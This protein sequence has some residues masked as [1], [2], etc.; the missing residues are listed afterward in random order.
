MRRTANTVTL[1]H[2]AA[3]DEMINY[4]KHILSAIFLFVSDAYSQDSKWVY[5]GT[6]D[7]ANYYYDS[8]TIARKGNTGEILIKFV[9]INPDEWVYCLAKYKVFFD[10]KKLQAESSFYYDKNGKVTEISSI[11]MITAEP[12]T[13]EESILNV[14][15]DLSVS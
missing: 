9:Y 5:V 8:K 6:S 1:N 13:A 7:E 3:D 10:E 15:N 11:E 12:E 14:F 2:C 4:L